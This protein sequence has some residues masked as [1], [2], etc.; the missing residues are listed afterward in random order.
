MS[1]WRRWWL[2]LLAAGVVGLSLFACLTWTPINYTVLFGV[3]GRYFL[4][5]LPLA[6]L[7]LGEE[8]AVYKKKQLRAPTAF[9]GISLCALVML[10]GL[11][12]YATL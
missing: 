1:G 9:A 4:P 12:I 6:L 8:K 10:Q 7:A 3:Q 5:V 2:V 11:S